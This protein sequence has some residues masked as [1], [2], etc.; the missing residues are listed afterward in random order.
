MPVHK[1]EI[2][3]FVLGSALQKTRSRRSFSKVS[4]REHHICE[5]ASWI[6]LLNQGTLCENIL[7]ARESMAE[8]IG[9]AFAKLSPVKETFPNFSESIPWEV[10]FCHHRWERWYMSELWS[11]QSLIGLTDSRVW[12]ANSIFICT[13]SIK[14]TYNVELPC[15]FS[16]KSG[17]LNYFLNMGIC[18]L[19]CLCCVVD[20]GDL[21]PEN[22][23]LGFCSDVILCGR[24]DSKYQLTN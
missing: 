12:S 23:L 17:S 8:S 10:A 2:C 20:L 18:L 5:A 11:S 15:D 7:C 3:R 14:E 16:V 6:E 9:C 13:E 22:T 24:L 4:L 21:D 19:M 1:A